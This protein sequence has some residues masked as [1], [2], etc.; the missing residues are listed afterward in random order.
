MVRQIPGSQKIVKREGSDRELYVVY[1]GLSTDAKPTDYL[2]TGCVF[3]EIDTG[4]V[5]FFDE[6]N[7]EWLKAGGDDE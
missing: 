6:E 7:N 5:Y 2:I 1:N 3:I 4:D